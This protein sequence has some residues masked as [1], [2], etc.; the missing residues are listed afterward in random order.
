MFAHKS[1]ASVCC[2]NFSE[3]LV[4]ACV[5]RESASDDEIKQ[6]SVVSNV[7]GGRSFTF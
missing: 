7:K 6:I 1:Q 3:S 4:S 5:Q 2:Y